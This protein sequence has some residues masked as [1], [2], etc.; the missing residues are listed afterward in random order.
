MIDFDQIRTEHDIVDLIGRH[1]QLKRK[2]DSSWMGLCPFHSE[3]TPSFNVNPQSQR[4]H[5]FGCA[6]RGDVVDFVENY[7][8]VSKKDAIKMLG[9]GGSDDDWKPAP[10]KE[11]PARPSRRRGRPDIPELKE[12]TSYDLKLISQNR[13]IPIDALQE[14]VRLECLWSCNWGRFKPEKCWM[15]T[16]KARVNGQVRRMDGGRFKDRKALTLPNS[17]AKWP[18]GIANVPADA[19]RIF[20]CEGGPDFL[21]A[22]A[23]ITDRSHPVAMVGASMEIHP[24]ALPY[25]TNRH[26]TILPHRDDAGSEAA[27]KWKE[28]LEPFTTVDIQELPEDDLNDCLKS[29]PDFVLL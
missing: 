7:N 26:V 19:K 10:K 15:I 23:A 25:M 13:K 22:F 11:K 6:A 8:G 17:W 21:A 20:I 29:E 3:K 2:S 5:C 9:G 27:K 16:D 1:V 14:A 28:Q 4:Y 12:P 18:I 24:A